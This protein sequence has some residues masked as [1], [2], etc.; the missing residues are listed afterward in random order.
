MEIVGD[1][2]KVY[3]E[4]TEENT[5]MFKILEARIKALKAKDQE[6]ERAVSTE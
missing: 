3:L 4:D 5:R 1:T 6:Q 2:M